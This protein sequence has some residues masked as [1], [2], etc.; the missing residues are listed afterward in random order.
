M[1]GV[2]QEKFRANF[3]LFFHHNINHY[4]LEIT[5]TLRIDGFGIERFFAGLK[6]EYFIFIM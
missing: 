3:C 1:F 6:D 2:D 5:N 4:Y